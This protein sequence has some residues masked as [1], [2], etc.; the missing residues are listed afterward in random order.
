MELLAFALA[1]L[2][3]GK[4]SEEVRAAVNKYLEDN[5]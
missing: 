1:L 4:T 3:E 5:P 2:A